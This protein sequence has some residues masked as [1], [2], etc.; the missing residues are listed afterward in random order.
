MSLLADLTPWAR[1]TAR[2]V[3]RLERLA[4]PSA[5]NGSRAFSVSEIA[6]LPPPVARYFDLVL[7]PGMSRVRFAALRHAGEF[8]T[9]ASKPFSRFT[10][11]Q[12]VSTDPPGFVWDARIHM[13]PFAPTLVRDSYL[14]GEGSML[15]TIAGLVPVVRQTG[16][17]AMARGALVR[18]LAEA[19]WYPTALLPGPRLT[20]AP[21]DADSARV[22]LVDRGT[23]VSLDVTFARDGSIDRV[24]TMRDRD[25]HGTSVLTRWTAINSRY[26]RVGGMLIPTHGEVSWDLPE[27]TFT[28]WRAH[29][30]DAH[31][32]PVQ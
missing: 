10:S 15:A 7:V 21:I 29:L 23:T 26:E 18:Y 30:V 9:E 14:G 6:R 8:R 17:P 1:V 11:V 27:G 5:A 20:W 32:I 3:S 4:S 2:E 13:M 28:Y 19:V 16:T 22:T 24:S 31:Y 12:H 25:V